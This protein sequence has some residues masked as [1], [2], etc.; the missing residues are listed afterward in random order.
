MKKPLSKFVK[1][2]WLVKILSH[3]AGRSI[4]RRT[5][6]AI[7]LLPP[8]KTILLSFVRMEGEAL[9]WGIIWGTLLATPNIHIVADPLVRNDLAQMLIDFEKEF[10]KF[11]AHPATL[12]S[13]QKDFQIFLPNSSHIE[14]LLNLSLRYMYSNIGDDLRKICLN[15]L[16]RIA[17]FLFLEST[18]TGQQL[19]HSMSTVVKEHYTSN[20]EDIR[21]EHLECILPLI[22]TKG[23]I[24]QLDELMAELRSSRKNN[25]IEVSNKLEEKIKSIIKRELIE[26]HLVLSESLIFFHEDQRPI[27]EGTTKLYDATKE[28][29]KKYFEQ[30]YKLL[31]GEK[32]FFPVPSTE[33]IQYLKPKIV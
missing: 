3:E 20:D 10:S 16:G 21:T 9:P 14:I 12:G 32:A 25:L 15:R 17:N 22:N 19:V 31:N 11:I 4:D 28:N 2:K 6:K 33:K 7:A 26:R 5:T 8:D 13:F 18:R 23:T 29:V 30:E 27:K 1:N 24:N